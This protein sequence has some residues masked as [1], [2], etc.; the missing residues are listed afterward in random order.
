MSDIPMLTIGN[1]E[2]TEDCPDIIRCERC[3]N[4]HRIE[5]GASRKSLPG[6]GWSDPVP[7]KLLG[8]VTCGGK[9]YLAS[10]NGKRFSAS[11]RE[12]RG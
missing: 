8:F 9:P 4:A 6:G 7:S 1:D 12:Q 11:R 5:Y 2:L 10:L 3:G